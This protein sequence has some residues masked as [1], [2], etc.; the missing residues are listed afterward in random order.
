MLKNKL[1]RPK[2]QN[3]LIFNHAYYPVLFEKEK[4]LL[5]ALERWNKVNIFPRRYFHP[6][7]TELPYLADKFECPVSK[8]V[9][10]RIVSLPLYVGMNDSDV[11]RVC[12][13]I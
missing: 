3:D 11:E 10:S 8:D 12:R 4:E 13:E 2:P 1:Q 9:S 6:S 7:L 5:A